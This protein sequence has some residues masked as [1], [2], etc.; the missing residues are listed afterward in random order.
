MWVNYYVTVRAENGFCHQNTPFEGKWG[1]LEPNMDLRSKRSNLGWL[2]AFFK[3]GCHNFASEILQGNATFKTS[4]KCHH[5]INY[6]NIYCILC[7]TMKMAILKCD[8]L[9]QILNIIMFLIS[10]YSL[11]RISF[12]QTLKAGKKSCSYQYYF[13]IRVVCSWLHLKVEAPGGNPLK[14][15]RSNCLPS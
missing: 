7:K 15:S 11:I 1:L 2:G 10:G 13:V 12:F 6:T 3:T 8:T 5:C 9:A 14:I 4:Y